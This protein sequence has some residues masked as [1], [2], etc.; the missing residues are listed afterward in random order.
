[1]FVVTIVTGAT[2]AREGV[3]RRSLKSPQRVAKFLVINSQR[4]SN[5]MKHSLAQFT[6]AATAAIVALVVAASPANAQETTAVFSSPTIAPGE[7]VTL[8]LAG[9]SPTNDIYGC[10]YFDDLPMG[11][12]GDWGSAFDGEQP[13]P[14][15]NLFDPSSPIAPVG[16]ATS[17]SVALF[18]AEVGSCPLTFSATINSRVAFATVT[19]ASPSGA[20]GGAATLPPTGYDPA[21]LAGLSSL[22]LVAGLGALTI[23]RRR[24]R[25]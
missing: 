25:G 14:Y 12:I 7:T 24:A 11:G 18:H 3:L 2:V 19:A 10:A 16:G 20:G 13:F 15:E 1:L 6:C 9:A 23:R 17:F 4:N 8:T 21:V 22:L 5:F